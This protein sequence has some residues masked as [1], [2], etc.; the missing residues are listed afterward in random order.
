M[1]K[2][3]TS[4]EIIHDVQTPE[5]LTYF[6]DLTQARSEMGVALSVAKS[7]NIKLRSI[8]PIGQLESCSPIKDHLKLDPTLNKS[9]QRLERSSTDG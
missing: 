8:D 3:S 7:M 4:L 2:K 1:G 9:Y 5:D 6:C